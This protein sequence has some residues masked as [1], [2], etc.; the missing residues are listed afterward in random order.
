MDLPFWTPEIG[1]DTLNWFDEDGLH[2]GSRSNPAHVA[3]WE[4]CWRE[5]EEREKEEDEHE[6]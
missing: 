5:F 3:E 2:I 6:Q 1:A 4:R